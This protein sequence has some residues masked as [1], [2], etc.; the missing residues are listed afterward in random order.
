[1]RRRIDE[2][3]V[4]LNLLLLLCR[5]FVDMYDIVGWVSVVD[6]GGWS[7][8]MAAEWKSTI[9]YNGTTYKGLPNLTLSIFYQTEH[10]IFT[11]SVLTSNILSSVTSNKV[12]NLK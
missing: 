3:I 2:R 5:Q 6:W 7:K 1:M 11:S 9:I 10:H 4:F 12:L 8:Y